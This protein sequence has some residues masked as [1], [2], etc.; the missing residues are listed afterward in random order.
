MATLFYMWYHGL[1]SVSL[2]IQ[3]EWLKKKRWM[4]KGFKKYNC[5]NY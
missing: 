5:G 4:V 3:G 1:K 2:F